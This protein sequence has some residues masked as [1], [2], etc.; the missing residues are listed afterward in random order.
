MSDIISFSFSTEG[1]NGNQG[2]DELHAAIRALPSVFNSASQVIED[3][4]VS[5]YED[6]DYLHLHWVVTRGQ[7]TN[8][9]AEAIIQ[10]VADGEV[11]ITDREVPDFPGTFFL[12]LVPDTADCEVIGCDCN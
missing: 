1:V 6:G 3:E 11:V 4:L 9:I 12:E 5:A 2:V 8:R 7:V 10:M